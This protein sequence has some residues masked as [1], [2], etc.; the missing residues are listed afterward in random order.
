MDKIYITPNPITGF[1]LKPETHEID[2]SFWT[3]DLNAAPIV[4]EITH[5]QSP[6]PDKIIF[7]SVEYVKKTDD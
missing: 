1:L 3:K 5:V 6:N 7:N 4:C 2:Y